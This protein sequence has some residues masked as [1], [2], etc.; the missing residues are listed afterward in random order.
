MYVCVCACVLISLLNRNFGRFSTRS[1]LSPARSSS[2][3]VSLQD[4]Q[5]SAIDRV[6]LVRCRRRS[7][8]GLPFK[9]ISPHSLLEEGLARASYSRLSQSCSLQQCNGE[10]NKPC[11]VCTNRLAE[12]AASKAIVLRS[13]FGHRRRRRRR[14]FRPEWYCLVSASSRAVPEI[15]TR[16]LYRK[17]CQNCYF[18]VIAAAV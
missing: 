9:G 16:W 2:R 13:L 1:S 5:I 18:R 3:R 17:C 7:Q 4:G 15:P 12:S 14:S 8:A 11:C 10:F 6:F